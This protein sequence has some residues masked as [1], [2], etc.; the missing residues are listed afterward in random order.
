MR[1]FRVLVASLLLSSATVGLADD[2]DGTV[3]LFNGTDLTDWD[4][5]ERFW[6]VQD[7]SIVGQT[8]D[9]NKAENNTFLIYRGGEFGDFEL[10]FEYQVEGFNS[11]IQYRSEEVGEYSI[12]GYQADFEARWHDDGSADKFSGMFFEEQGRMFMG[13]R[14]EA[15]VVR[16]NE[17]EPMSPEIDI[18]GSLGDAAELETAINR[19]GWNSYRIIADGH[20]FT[21]IINDRV[22]SVAFDEDTK[23]RKD[24]GLIALQLHSGPPMKIMVKNLSLKPLHGESD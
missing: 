13:Q 24:S 12:K 5:D 9:E 17:G 21:H 18:I 14:G 1:F 22:M 2:A 19:D 20:T 4:G 16:T 15:V 10:T 6:R 3:S 23:H 7:G 11:G 8:T